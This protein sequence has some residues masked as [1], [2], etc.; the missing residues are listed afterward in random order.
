M[1]LKRVISGAQTGVDRAALDAAIDA[2]IPVDGFCIKG[3]RAED[4][5]I[6][7][8]YPFLEL[9]TTQYSIRIE[10]NVVVS[11]GTLIINK[12]PLS[13]GTKLSYDFAVKNLMPCLIVQLDAEDKI[14][15]FQVV[16]W[17]EGQR[18]VTLNVTGPRE[19]KIP[20]GIYKEAYSYLERLFS[21]IKDAHGL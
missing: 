20:E 18:I 8:T 16:R 19:S 2:S 12:G 7:E 17:I 4:G 9:E 3:R 1:V 11:D 21:D 14:T 5:I 15:P 6:P 13:H 10:H